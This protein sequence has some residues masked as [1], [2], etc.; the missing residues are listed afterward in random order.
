VT[1][2]AVASIGILDCPEWVRYSNLYR[3]FRVQGVKMKW[4]PY[5]F[6]TG[7]VNIIEEELLAGSS[8][9]GDGLT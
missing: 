6:A 9:V 7:T 4:L 3:Y 8:A 1:A 5:K 2:P